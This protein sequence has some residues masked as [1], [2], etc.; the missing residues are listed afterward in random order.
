LEA[1]LGTNRP[2]GGWFSDPHFSGDPAVTITFG[3]GICVILDRYSVKS[4]FEQRRSPS[5]RSWVLYGRVSGE[6]QTLDEHRGP[7]ALCDGR[8][9]AFSIGAGGLAIDAVR[10]C[11][12]GRNR[13][14]SSQMHLAGLVLC[15]D[16]LAVPD[17]VGGGRGFIAAERSDGMAVRLPGGDSRAAPASGVAADSGPAKAD[18]DC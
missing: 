2:Q 4:G 15:G 17:L 6:W 5:L 14:G 3:P 11:A 13:L 18:V 10:L 16:I 8:L 1:V 7:D 12:I 9:H